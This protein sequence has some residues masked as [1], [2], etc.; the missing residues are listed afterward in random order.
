MPEGRAT[1]AGLWSG[2]AVSPVDPAAIVE[3]VAHS[4]MQGDAAHPFGGRTEPDENMAESGYSWCKAPRLDGQSAEV[5]ALARQIV[6][7]WLATEWGPDRHARRVDKITGVEQRYL[8]SGDT[9]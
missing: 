6:D 1:K 8:R 7:E 3:H 9:P 5:G 2:G 4:W